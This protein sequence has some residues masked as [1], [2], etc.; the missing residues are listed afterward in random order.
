MKRVRSLEHFLQNMKLSPSYQLTTELKKSYFTKLSEE[1]KINSI[2]HDWTT[3]GLFDDIQ[4]HFN[5]YEEKEV[6]EDIEKI[7]DNYCI[8][9]ELLYLNYKQIKSVLIFYYSEIKKKF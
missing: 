8:R 5:H 2:L 3:Y 1:C 6:L 4:K 9:N 7:V